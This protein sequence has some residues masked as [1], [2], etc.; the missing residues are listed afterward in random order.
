MNRH[1]SRKGAPGI[2]DVARRAG[3]SASTVSRFYNSPELV[4]NTTRA[5]IK[6]SAAE[7]GYIR[8]RMAGTLH[9]RFSGTIGLVVPTINNAI[10]SE[11]IEAFSSR[12]QIHDRT[13][14]I[15][16]H[17]YNLELEVSI[18]RSLLERR[19]DGVAIVGHDHSAVA[20]EM[21]AVRNIPV[22]SLWNYNPQASVTCIGCDNRQAGARVTR[23]LLELG[24]RDI[25][26]LFPDT[27]GND[28]ARDRKDGAL[29]MAQ[30]LNRVVPP[31]RVVS[32]PYDIALA[33]SIAFDIIKHDKPSAFVCGNDI[34]AQGVVY[35]A[36][37]AGIK[38][39]MELSVVGIGDFS[40]SAEMEPGLTTLRLPARSIGTTAADTIIE[41]SINSSPHNHVG[42]LPHVELPTE[43]ILRRSTA[44]IPT[45]SQP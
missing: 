44:A 5:I 33:K 15:A 41:M 19:I 24:H 20:M 26:F 31:S 39:P 17:N 40:G 4:T 10:F 38:L 25:A 14:L 29:E 8:D 37:Q 7:L 1:R 45:R 9:N 30:Q 35:A 34:I 43:L 13:M 2:V 23:H 32:C 42:S 6:K 16:S 27:T 28:R 36:Q 21:L 22:I 18:V 3:V 11:L 12:L